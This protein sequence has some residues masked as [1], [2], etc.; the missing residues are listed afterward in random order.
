MNVYLQNAPLFPT[1]VSHKKVVPV[2][3]RRVHVNSDGIH[4]KILD[5]RR[6]M[7]V[8]TNQ[9]LFPQQQHIRQRLQYIP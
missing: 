3:D 4:S 2:S 7:S 1:G 6:S 8:F 9:I 5:A